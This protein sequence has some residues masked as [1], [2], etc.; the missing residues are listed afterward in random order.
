VAETRAFFAARAQSW[1]A[2]FGD[3]QPAY[4]QAVAES[5]VPVG[6][7]VADVGC[8]TG[9]ALPAIRAAVG[10]GGVVVGVDLTPQMLAVA[11]TRVAGRARLL[12][13]DARHLPLAGACVDMVFAAGLVQHLPDTTA[14]LGE[15]A[16]ITR[17][18]GRLVIFHPSGRAAL[19]ARH[20]RALRDDDPL[21]AGPLE[22]ALRAAGWVLERYDDPPH[23]F[24]ALATRV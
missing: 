11:T 21:A 14:G 9:R 19:A 16:R 24:L 1:D 23:R 6:A 10:P 7:V 2:K 13:A 17:P 15:L 20:G 22:A 8:G 4:E 3:D 18:G 12:L 5:G